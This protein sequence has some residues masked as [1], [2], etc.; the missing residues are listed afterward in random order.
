[1]TTTILPAITRTPSTDVLRVLLD[2]A[3]AGA[4]T[5]DAADTYSSSRPEGRALLS[6]AALARRA[7]GS[8]GAEQGVA[9]TSGP[10]ILVQRDLAAAARL[11]DEAAEAADGEPEEIADLLV[12]AQRLFSQLL[13]TTR[14]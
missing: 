12:P 1:M 3:L 2:E 6:L 14:S 4:A 9:L 8:L 11:L 7:A 13:G 5:D 10:G